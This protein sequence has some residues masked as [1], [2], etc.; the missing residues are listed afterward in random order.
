RPMMDRQQDLVP[1]GMPVNDAWLI[2][3]IPGAGKTTLCPLLAA[4]FSRRV[5]IPGDHFHMWIMSGRVLP[6]HAPAAEAQRQ[7]SLS[8]R[9]QTLLARA[10]AGAGFVPVLDYVVVTRERLDRYRQALADFALYL[11][12]LD[13]GRETAL[14]RDRARPEETVDEPSLHDD[15]VRELSG[16]GLWIDNRA[17]RPEASVETILE[18]SAEARLR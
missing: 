14:A 12:V 8:V 11:V 13:P 4:R 6:G 18:R 10:Y 3:G 7:M 16:V 9:I 17:M 5:Y 15:L 2:T 1:D